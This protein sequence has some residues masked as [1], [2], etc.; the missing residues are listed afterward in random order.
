MKIKDK[1]KSY[2]FWVSLA[3]AVILIL[4]V[5]GNRFG[6]TV[7]E[8]MVSDLFTALCSILVLLG[9]IVVPNNTNNQPNIQKDTAN[10]LIN[11]IE[12][13]Q[14]CL[15][16]NSNSTNNQEENINH[17]N[18]NINLND[19]T[20]QLAQQ[21]FQDNTINTENNFL[22]ETNSTHELDDVITNDEHINDTYINQDEVA[23]SENYSMDNTKNQATYN[24]LTQDSSQIIDEQNKPIINQPIS[25]IS[26][27][28]DLFNAEREK[29]AQNIN[30]YI[31]ELQE[32]IR[33]AR[34]KM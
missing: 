1:I 20:Q 30:E 34:E 9:I 15:D 18:D 19:E 7:D 33:K 10:S 3:S 23:S 32:E 21:D 29:F 14:D 13:T 16:D 11:N 17:S 31:F 24:I 12:Q 26:N 5:L 8:T 4:K 27:L 6:F 28:K 25:N 2:S 22:E